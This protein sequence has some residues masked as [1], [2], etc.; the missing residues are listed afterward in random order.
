MKK[1]LK[2]SAALIL[3]LLMLVSLVPLVP[4]E[5]EAAASVETV[6]IKLSMPPVDCGEA[7]SMKVTISGKGCY[8]DSWEWK[9]IY[10]QKIT[11]KFDNH[12]AT[13]EVYLSASPG[14]NFSETTRVTIDGEPVGFSFGDDAE[15]IIVSKTYS[16]VIWKPSVSKHPAEEEVEVGKIISFVSYGSF[17]NESKWLITDPEGNTF[18]AETLPDKVPGVKVTATYDK[19]NISPAKEELNGYKVKCEFKG[20]GGEIESRAAKIV[21]VDKVEE[22]EEEEVVVEEGHEHQFGE[23]IFSDAGYHWYECECG[24]KKNRDEHRYVW[25]QFRA[26]DLEN[27]GIIAAQCSVC[28]H[29]LQGEP[30]LSENERKRLLEEAAAPSPSPIPSDGAS[31]VPAETAAPDTAVEGSSQPSATPAETPV[32]EE[33]SKSKY[34]EPGGIVVPT[35]TPGKVENNTPEPTATPSPT[36][37]PAPSPSPTPSPTPEIDETEEG[38]FAKLFGWFVK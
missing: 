22:K 31:A 21:I 7:K 35:V 6:E 1:I 23:E 5:A 26:A 13:I 29:V 19:L 3:S 14:N 18:D 4:L 30:Q 33:N 37:S 27:T 28:N 15:H 9:D 10:G 8:L 34:L 17:V 32:P 20:P 2:K 12:D 16:P 11:D 24:A 25:I 38:F 36:P